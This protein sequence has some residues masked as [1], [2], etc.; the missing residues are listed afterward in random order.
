MCASVKHFQLQAL[1][2]LACMSG[3]LRVKEARL[4]LLKLIGKT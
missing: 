1:G 2:K 4:D 3:V